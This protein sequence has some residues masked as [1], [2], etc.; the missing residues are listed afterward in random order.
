MAA[1]VAASAKTPT[2]AAPRAVPAVSPLRGSTVEEYLAGLD[3]SQ[4]AL[5]SALCALVKE[6]APEATVSIKWAQPVFEISGPMIF[7]KPATH[8]TTLGFWRGT[9]LT[10]PEGLL[11][12]EGDRMRHVKVA[13][14][15]DLKRDLL[16]PL[17][18]QAATLNR[19]KGDPTKA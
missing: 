16:L 3:A 1:P 11:D 2:P 6:G 13:K 15:E 5:V 7:V 9:E 19:T 17:I 12:G 10:A 4:A 18:Q 14:L 8:H